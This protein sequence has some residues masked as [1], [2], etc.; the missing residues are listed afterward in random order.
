MKYRWN[1]DDGLIRQSKAMAGK[2]STLH[3]LSHFEHYPTSKEDSTLFF[4]G[5][6][7]VYA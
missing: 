3:R 5:G 2:T 7:T 4:L 6:G 1:G